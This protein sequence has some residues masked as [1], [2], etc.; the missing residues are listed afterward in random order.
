MNDIIGILA[1]FGGVIMVLFTIFWVVI[2]VIELKDFIDRIVYA[3]KRKHRFNGPPVAKCYCKDCTY[4]VN[5]LYMT[6]DEGY[7]KCI[8]ANRSECVL[9]DNGFCYLAVPRKKEKK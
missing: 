2:G 3:Y 7:C 8:P 1:L 9:P 6:N 4:F 5:G